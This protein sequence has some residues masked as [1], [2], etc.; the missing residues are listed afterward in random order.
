MSSPFL[1][2]RELLKELD[3][4]D[5]P[6]NLAADLCE[7]LKKYLGTRHELGTSRQGSSSWIPAEFLIVVPDL[8]YLTGNF[9]T[10]DVSEA[11]IDKANRKHYLDLSYNNFSISGSQDNQG[12]QDENT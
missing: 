5:T 10:G 2:L 7:H 11:W 4:R 6:L 9:L 8:L 1:H 12:C 3:F